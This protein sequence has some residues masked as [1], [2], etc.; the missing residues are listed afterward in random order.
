MKTRLIVISVDSLIVED[1][2]ILY[3][4]PNFKLIMDNGSRV[5]TMES[6][7]PT[8]TYPAHVSMMTGCYPDKHG[9]CNNLVLSP[10]DPDPDWIISIKDVKVKTIFHAAKERGYTTACCHW[11]VC[12]HAGE[13]IDYLIPE[14]W[15]KKTDGDM[16]ARYIECGASGALDI[17]KKN[18]YRLR[19]KYFPMYDEFITDCACDIIREKS[20]DVLFIHYSEIDHLRHRH[21]LFGHKITEGLCRN[22]DWIGQIFDAVRQ[23]GMFDRTNIVITSDHGQLEVKRNIHLNTLLVNEGLIKLNSDY[24]VASWDAFIQSA[25][26]SAQVYLKRPDDKNL[27]Q[28]V[29]GML[30]KMAE[31][32][33]YGFNEVYTTEEVQSRFNLSGE[34][35]FIIETDGYSR[36]GNRLTGPVVQQ[37]AFSD[38]R[39]KYGSHGHIPSK[40]PQPP[41]LCMGP[42][43]KQG[44]IIK[45]GRIIDQAPTY[46]KLLGADLPEADG[47]PID[48]LLK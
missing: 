7:Y 12:A 36:F 24:S 38:Y 17:L 29:Y 14:V 1:L 37:L 45:S 23:A 44:V 30:S 8:L 20:P 16:V 13:Y 5:N 33:L 2:S 42:D 46:A 43:F 21:G 11:P 9:L 34:F 40:G 4:L 19:W 39:F 28:K 48:A 35:S 3:T 47:E 26:L 6:I 10:G 18:S 31:D 32:G 25:G 41:F 22:D 15:T 27:Y